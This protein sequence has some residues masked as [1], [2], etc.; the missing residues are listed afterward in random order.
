MEHVLTSRQE[1]SRALLAVMC[2]GVISCVLVGC[3]HTQG[4]RDPSHAGTQDLRSLLPA[5][6]EGVVMVDVRALLAAPFVPRLDAVFEPLLDERGRQLRELLDRV[7]EVAIGFRYREVEGHGEPLLAIARGRFTEADLDTFGRTHTAGEH[8]GHTL[9]SDD[10][11]SL[12][13]SGTHTLA[14]GGEALV[15]AALDRMD[16]LSPATGPTRPVLLDAA[17]RAQLGQHTLTYAAETSERFRGEFSEEFSARGAAVSVGAW[18]DIGSAL[19]AH[20]FGLFSD[21]A[22]AMEVAEQLMG[23]LAEA[24][25]EPQLEEL[26]MLAVINAIHVQADGPTVNVDVSF[27]HETVERIISIVL[28]GVQAGAAFSEPAEEPE[29]A[30]TDHR[31]D[32]SLDPSF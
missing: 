27:D 8:R 29:Q 5:D 28:L 23:K 26:G 11:M 15:L 22:M 31:D 6:S 17:R 7:D 14:F 30:Q 24:A 3:G 1:R 20:G 32:L 12:S 2:L 25:N 4:P 16:G 21:D 9:R 13:L 19:N 10:G 18:V